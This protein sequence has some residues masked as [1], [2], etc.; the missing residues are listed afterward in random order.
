MK[1]LIV[2]GLVA[3]FVATTALITAFYKPTLSGENDR[4]AL[5]SYP[6]AV[7]QQ[8]PV[9]SKVTTVAI[10]PIRPMSNS[11]IRETIRRPTFYVFEGIQGRQL[12]LSLWAGNLTAELFTPSG[13]RL[14][15]L[16]KE[17]SQWVG[18]LPES[19]VYRILIKP[20]TEKTSF[21]LEREFKAEWTYNSERAI[22]IA[23][24]ATATE[25]DVKL[26][27]YTIQP[28]T[29]K[30]KAGQTMTVTAKNVDVA[31][32]A[33]AGQLLDQGNGEATAK[34][35]ESGVYQVLIVA[36]TPIQTLVKVVLR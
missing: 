28:L 5:N 12:T 2:S 17:V 23:P 20:K 16:E 4:Q 15:V 27:A 10:E 6:V 32:A 7:T 11:E 13:E 9:V 26:S 25:V 33:P 29:V 24:R 30:A 8:K 21:V 35:P 1:R 19:G 18:V 34:L 3:T 31:I 22:A 14:G 36:K